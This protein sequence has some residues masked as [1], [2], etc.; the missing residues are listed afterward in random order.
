MGTGDGLYKRGGR[1]WLR[2]DPVTGKPIS[3][4]AR[5]RA[6]AVAFQKRRER[7]AADPAHAAATKATVEE[8]AQRLLTLKR[9]TKAEGT[10]EMYEQ[11]LGHVLRIG[12]PGFRMAQIDP[13]WVDAYFAQR[14]EEGAAEQTLARELTAIMQLCKLASRSGQYGRLVSS[15]RPPGFSP[16]FVARER[17]LPPAEL[18]ALLRELPAQKA[19]HVAFIVATGARRGEVTRATKADVDL[20]RGV[21]KLRGTKTARSAREVP[22][23][24]AL[25]PLLEAALPWLPLSP[26]QNE[27]RDILRGCERA[28]I[29]PA[30]WNDL[31]RTTATWL[32]RSG[33]A[34]ELVS[35]VLGHS[36]TAMV[37]RCYGQLSAES[38][39][40]LA[41][42]QI[43]SATIS[44]QKRAGSHDSAS[45][46]IAQLAELRIFNPQSWSAAIGETAVLTPGREAE[47]SQKP[48][49]NRGR[50]YNI[51]TVRPPTEEA[52]IALVALRE[53]A[54]ALGV[55]EAE[56]AI[57]RAL[58]AIA[59][60][61]SS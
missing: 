59:S 45:G 25:R 35:K 27:R 6:A 32:V 39:G 5:D 46:P 38:V 12:G 17:W 57:L 48:A 18:H 61:A 36:S 19:A 44:R 24:D 43:T 52:R 33:V 53:R 1:W 26:W 7:E 21:V 50:T 54:A 2:T 47:G 34:H 11:K 58:D 56:D 60:E 22:I 40:E 4:G 51:V 14:R 3:T 37:Y 28:K 16:R 31:R 42:S 29:A 20:A 9:S 49:P 13:A 23:F 30:T 10:V 15:L 8:W 55:I 41:E